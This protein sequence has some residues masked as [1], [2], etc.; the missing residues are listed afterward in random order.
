MI[1]FFWG[2]IRKRTVFRR[3]KIRKKYETEPN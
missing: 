3:K 1:F 2:N